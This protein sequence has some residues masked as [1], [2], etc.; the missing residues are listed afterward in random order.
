MNGPKTTRVRAYT[1]QLQVSNIYAHSPFKVH[2]TSTQGESLLQQS[3]IDKQIA[4]AVINPF[5]MNDPNVIGAIRRQEGITNTSNYQRSQAIGGAVGGAAGLA[6]GVYKYG[7]VVLAG[8]KAIGAVASSVAAGSATLSWTGVGA[9]VAGAAA[10]VAI[11]MNVYTGYQL[12]KSV[13]SLGSKEGQVAWGTYLKNIGTSM[14]N[15]PVTT[16]LSIGG[17]AA[18]HYGLSKIGMAAAKPTSSILTQ[19]VSKIINFG[20][21]KMISTVAM[22]KGMRYVGGQID[23]QLL[24]EMTEGNQA[25]FTTLAALGGDLRDM[26]SLNNVVKAIAATLPKGFEDFDTLIKRSYGD[27]EDGYS[28]LGFNKVREAYGL[29]IGTFGNGVIDMLGEVMIHTDGWITKISNSKPN[30]LT[31]FVTNEVT[32]RILG[33]ENSKIFNYFFEKTKD[34]LTGKT[35][36]SQRKLDGK[37]TVTLK[38]LKGHISNI[39]LN[40]NTKKSNNP[41]KQKNIDDFNE[42]LIK[43]EI[44]KISQILVAN[45]IRKTGQSKLSKAKV[46]DIIKIV[47]S[48][49][50]YIKETVENIA[51]DIDATNQMIVKSDAVLK[52]VLNT[53]NKRKSFNLDSMVLQELSER[54]VVFSGAYLNKLL[55]TNSTARM[56]VINQYK[57]NN[58]IDWITMPTRKLIGSKEVHRKLKDSLIKISSAYDP[59]KVKE[60]LDSISNRDLDSD[61]QTLTGMTKEQIKQMEKQL[62][63]KQDEINNKLNERKESFLNEKI[64]EKFGEKDTLQTKM[65]ELEQKRKEL[66]KPK[67]S[68]EELE[69][70]KIAYE[71]LNKELED[72]T[73]EWEEHLNI[74]GSYLQKVHKTANTISELRKIVREH[75]KNGIAIKEYEKGTGIYI[76]DD[77]ELKEVESIIEHYSKNTSQNLENKENILKLKNAVDRYNFFKL[78]KDFS[79]K[80]I[81]LIQNISTTILSIEEEFSKFRGTIANAY[82]LL[83]RVKIDLDT[84]IKEETDNLNKELKNSPLTQEKREQE[85]NA[86]I[87][88]R[89]KLIFQKYSEFKEDDFRKVFGETPEDS[90]IVKRLVELRSTGKIAIDMNY[91]TTI[92]TVLSE[93]KGEIV[94]FFMPNDIERFEVFSKYFNNESEE[95]KKILE[96]IKGLENASILGRPNQPKKINYSKETAAKRDALVI[97]LEKMFKAE[98]EDPN[99]PFTQEDYD[100]IMKNKKDN[101]KKIVNS[102]A[103]I[104]I[105]SKTK[106][107]PIHKPIAEIDITRSSLSKMALDRFAMK[108]FLETPLI[109]KDTNFNNMVRSLEID[110]NELNKRITTAEEEFN[111]KNEETLVRN[112]KIAFANVTNSSFLFALNSKYR[113]LGVLDDFVKDFGFDLNNTGN[114]NSLKEQTDKAFDSLS[115]QKV[116]IEQMENLVSE[117]SSKTDKDEYTKKIIQSV[118]ENYKRTKGLDEDFIKEFGKDETKVDTI[119]RLQD[120]YGGIVE[121]ISLKIAK[122]NNPNS[123]AASEEDVAKAWSIVGEIIDEHSKEEEIINL[124]EEINYKV[125]KRNQEIKEIEESIIILDKKIQENIENKNETETLTKERNKLNKQLEIKTK[126]NYTNYRDLIFKHKLLYLIPPEN[127]P[128]TVRGKTTFQNKGITE[129]SPFYKD[130]IQKV[131]NDE[132]M[133]L[134]EKIV[135][136]KTLPLGVFKN[137]GGFP[138]RLNSINQIKDIDFWSED[139]TLKAFELIPIEE[140]TGISKYSKTVIEF[141][142]GQGYDSKDAPYYIQNMYDTTHELISSSKDERLN[143]DFYKNKENSTLV[144]PNSNEE[145]NFSQLTQ[146]LL[147]VIRNATEGNRILNIKSINVLKSQEQDGS[148]TIKNYGKN[149]QELISNFEIIRIN[150]QKGEYVDLLV[151][152]VDTEK[153]L[154][155]INGST[156]LKQEVLG[157]ENKTG[158]LNNIRKLFE[159]SNNLIKLLTKKP[160]EKIDIRTQMF[161]KSIFEIFYDKTE[162]GE[163]DTKELINHFVYVP[164]DASDTQLAMLKQVTRIPPHKRTSF[165]R[166]SEENLNAYVKFLEDNGMD[167]YVTTTTGNVAFKK[168][169]LEDDNKKEIQTSFHEA[170]A[171]GYMQMTNK[172]L[173]RTGLDIVAYKNARKLGENGGEK[174]KFSTHHFKDNKNEKMDFKDGVNIKVKLQ[175]F[176]G[177]IKDIDGNDVFVSN[178]EDIVLVKKSVIERMYGSVEEY[179]LQEK[180]NYLKLTDRYSNKATIR[181]IDNETFEKNFDKNS[182]LIYSKSSNISRQ[183]QPQ[184]IEMYFNSMSDDRFYYDNDKSLNENLNKLYGRTEQNKLTK[185]ELRKI[186]EDIENIDSGEQYFFVTEDLE[187]PDKLG[188]YVEPK[189]TGDK[190]NVYSNAFSDEVMSAIAGTKYSYISSKDKDGKEVREYLD[191]DGLLLKFFGNRSKEENALHKESFLN[192]SEIMSGKRG[193]IKNEAFKFRQKNSI[194]DKLTSD[195]SLKPHQISITK[196]YAIDSGIA[197]MVKGKLEFFENSNHGLFIRYP[198]KGRISL[199]KV[200]IVIRPESDTDTSKIGIPLSYAKATNSDFDGDG[201]MLRSFKGAD[202]KTIEAAE[203][204]F[205]HDY[206]KV[207]KNKDGTY[208]LDPNVKMYSDHIINTG[209]KELDDAF[210]KDLLEK[211]NTDMAV[212]NEDGKIDMDKTNEFIKSRFVKD[213][214]EKTKITSERESISPKNL[215]Y[216]TIRNQMVKEFAAKNQDVIDYLSQS[217]TF[218]EEFNYWF[219]QEL[220]GEEKRKNNI[221]GITDPQALFS[222]GRELLAQDAFDFSKRGGTSLDLLDKAYELIN[223]YSDNNREDLKLLTINLQKVLLSMLRWKNSSKTIGEKR[224]DNNFRNALKKIENETEDLKKSFEENEEEVIFAGKESNI[225]DQTVEEVEGQQERKKQIDIN[226]IIEKKLKDNELDYTL[227]NQYSNNI[228]E[229]DAGMIVGENGFLIQ[230]YSN[231]YLDGVNQSLFKMLKNNNLLSPDVAPGIDGKVESTGAGRDTIGQYYRNIELVL[232]WSLVSSLMKNNLLGEAKNIKFIITL[233]NNETETFTLED[234]F[235]S[236]ATKRKVINITQK[237]TELNK[238]LF[239]FSEKELKTIQIV[240]ETS[241]ISRGFLNKISERMY[242]GI[243]DA[244]DSAASL[245]GIESSNMLTPRTYAHLFYRLGYFTNF[246][247]DLTSQHEGEETKTAFGRVIRAILSDTNDNTIEGNDSILIELKE[248]L[249]PYILTQQLITAIG[250]DNA[251]L[252][253]IYTG[254]IEI[255]GLFSEIEHDIKNPRSIK[256][257]KNNRD[258]NL[259]L[260]GVL[261]KINLEGSKDK[262]IIQEIRFIADKLMTLNTTYYNANKF[263]LLED[264]K[265]IDIITNIYN[266]RQSVKGEGEEF[267]VGG[268]KFLKED[269]T[270]F[271]ASLDESQTETIY[272]IYDFLRSKVLVSDLS[273]NQKG[274]ILTS[275]DNEQKSIASIENG[276]YMANKELGLTYFSK[277]TELNENGGKDILFAFSPV[278]ENIIITSR[279]KMT[280]VGLQRNAEFTDTFYDKQINLEDTE[281]TKEILKQHEGTKAL[282]LAGFSNQFYRDNIQEQINILRNVI[283]EDLG[284]PKKILEMLLNLNIMA[285]KLGVQKS[286]SIEELRILYKDIFKSSIAYQEK[287]EEEYDKVT[288]NKVYSHIASEQLF[289]KN[290][291]EDFFKL[292]DTINAPGI[293]RKNYQADFIAYSLL[294]RVLFNQNMVNWFSSTMPNLETSYNSIEEIPISERQSYMQKELHSIGRD[295]L[296]KRQQLESTYSMV[297]YHLMSQLTSEFVSNENKEK[298]I[299][300]AF[301]DKDKQ[302]ELRKRINDFENRKTLSPTQKTFDTYSWATDEHANK[303]KKILK[304]TLS[305]IFWQLTKESDLYP[306]KDLF[307]TTDGKIDEKELLKRTE[308]F[309]IEKMKKE[310]KDFNKLVGNKRLHTALIDSRLNLE[311]FKL[312]SEQYNSNKNV[313]KHLNLSKDMANAV[314]EFRKNKGKFVFFDTE[315][316]INGNKEIYDLSY[317]IYENGQ[318][319]YHQN[320]LNAFFD[321]RNE[322]FLKTKLGLTQKEFNNLVKRTS[323]AD[324]DRSKRVYEEFFNHAENSYLIGHSIEDNIFGD[325]DIKK[326]NE[327]YEKILKGK[328]TSYLRD[329][330][331]DMGKIKDS[332]EQFG[333]DGMDLSLI[334]TSQQYQMAYSLVQ[335]LNYENMKKFLNL[336]GG[337]DK[338]QYEKDFYMNKVKEIQEPFINFETYKQPKRIIKKHLMNLGLDEKVSE[339]LWNLFKDTYDK[340]VSNGFIIQKK[341]SLKWDQDKKQAFINLEE[342]PEESQNDLMRLDYEKGN[343]FAEAMFR[344]NAFNVIMPEIM[345]LAMVNGVKFKQAVQIRSY[346]S[347]FIKGFDENN[348]ILVS[349]TATFDVKTT[350]ALEEALRF[351]QELDIEQDQNK[352]ERLETSYLRALKK[353][354]SLHRKSTRPRLFENVGLG[355]DFEYEVNDKIGKEAIKLY[356][357]ERLEDIEQAAIRLSNPGKKASKQMGEAFDRASTKAVTRL[358]AYYNI[359]D[360]TLEEFK[361]ILNISADFPDLNDMLTRELLYLKTNFKELKANGLPDRFGDINGNTDNLIEDEDDLTIAYIEAAF[362]KTMFDEDN[363]S[364]LASIL[365]QEVSDFENTIKDED[366]IDADLKTF[367]DQ[368]ISKKIEQDFNK[369]IFKSTRV[370]LKNLFLNPKGNEEKIKEYFLNSPIYKNKA[371][372]LREMRKLYKA[373]EDRFEYLKANGIELRKGEINFKDNR[374]ERWSVSKDNKLIYLGTQSNKEFRK[375]AINDSWKEFNE[376][377]YVKEII[378]NSDLN[379]PIRE[380]ISYKE[381]NKNLYYYG[382]HY[383]NSLYQIE[384]EISKDVRRAYNGYYRRAN[385]AASLSKYQYN[386]FDMIESYKIKDG[387]DTKRLFHDIKNGFLGNNYY[388]TMITDLAGKEKELFLEREAEFNKKNMDFYRKK[389]KTSNQIDFE[390]FENSML[391]PEEVLKNTPVPY[392]KIIDIKNEDEL[393]RFI[394][395]AGEVEIGFTTKYDMMRVERMMNMDNRLSPVLNFINNTLVFFQKS[396]MVFNPGF[397][398]NMLTSGIKKNYDKIILDGN[399]VGGTKRFVSEGMKA[400]SLDSNYKLHSTNNLKYLSDLKS[401]SIKLEEGTLTDNDIDVFKNRLKNQTDAITIYLQEILSEEIGS[402]NYKTLSIFRSKINQLLTEMNKV[403]ED[404]TLT[405]KEKQQKVDFYLKEYINE[406]TK[407]GFITRIIINNYNNEEQLDFSTDE[408]KIET[409]EIIENMRLV[410]DIYKKRIIADPYGIYTRKEMKHIQRSL[411]D[412]LFNSFKENSI[413]NGVQLATKMVTPIR[414]LTSYINRVNQL[415]GIL[416]DIGSGK[417][418]MEA[419]NNSIKTFFNYGSRGKLENEMVLMFPFMSYAIRNIDYYLELINNP[420]YMTFIGNIAQGARTWYEDEDENDSPYDSNF[421]TRFAQERGWIPLGKNY[422]IKMNNQMYSAMNFLGDIGKGLEVRTNPLI[423]QIGNLTKGEDFSFG[424]AFGVENSMVANGFRAINKIAG[425]EVKTPADIMPSVFYADEFTKYT[426]YQYRRSKFGDYR[427]L[428]NDLFFQDGSR[429]KPSRN[430][431]TTSKNILYKAFVNR[432]LMEKYRYENR[433]R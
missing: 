238:K 85:L 81:D 44:S 305:N 169:T 86:R 204:A 128:F 222:L 3:L 271:K 225:N 32:L 150:L 201:G 26:T 282:G 113:S 10:I 327:E 217:L 381:Y 174:A 322:N 64:K 303:G 407:T 223:P 155:T 34:P 75:V 232:R 398:L 333:V 11:G 157:E 101:F 241:K 383:E 365:E 364:T 199:V 184:L 325:G 265:I 292:V 411:D 92:I 234:V 306:F 400:M 94:N 165:E 168:F 67:L 296:F 112:F 341:Y 139:F 162:I 190:T 331:I 385:K 130:D 230:N 177:S 54:N 404:T 263:G 310:Y 192:S 387:Y 409:K 276:L 53:N 74:E 178:L 248:R 105:R 363:P 396:M 123:E 392:L 61:K 233:A 237:G 338:T 429:R 9:I 125:E 251:L 317:V 206:S 80:N 72:L 349:D 164:K 6:F 375:Q 402:N 208:S 158:Y 212:K 378:T 63:I 272:K 35:K 275:L 295:I 69:K 31:S 328:I 135:Y 399:L 314:L 156:Y 183:S 293:K 138:V 285:Q 220:L 115:G 416:L 299:E 330:D 329:N 374:L 191:P 408:G 121:E 219:H 280:K 372:A 186:Y 187:N 297:P 96:L 172:N 170:Y 202:L 145:K 260:E 221:L 167:P 229:L 57:A 27:H 311:V 427:N 76:K 188:E 255:E 346:N 90:P 345:K 231:I 196:K 318:I 309:I 290:M 352:K 18:Y 257:G 300:Q 49:E 410:D 160:G 25:S 433:R 21:F 108:Y 213:P 386:F 259:I 370:E 73:K 356:D 22:N 137:S 106:D 287:R 111:G 216:A 132:H 247:K 367:N 258:G 302:T 368:I 215:G 141:F 87:E 350:A 266:I 249:T 332:F 253:N 351:K 320:F 343:I 243:K 319:S 339:E 2:V 294:G 91:E 179:N 104:A 286:I 68:K 78:F 207:I 109:K 185:A 197:R 51:N 224:A 256:M 194:Y 166:A 98:L 419:Y 264:E 277:R 84:A 214:S 326:L 134:E 93:S 315:N 88:K 283:E 7:G 210:G 423:R 23:N 250:G 252:S 58:I 384:D 56:A 354:E 100:A 389:I 143:P 144:K 37:E 77:E 146:D 50:K 117:M 193:S 308:D 422:G 254:I 268:I 131:I 122:K 151:P 335:A 371:E 261:K 102:F 171:P 244:L 126:Q 120:A 432:R 29:D 14:V 242:S 43:T 103:F 176:H 36:I 127:I 95:S 279:N 324:F 153:G 236:K 24:G 38:S 71:N 336:S 289:G 380:S 273:K 218:N 40:Y 59:I 99:S 189:V 270:D 19:N 307:N 55:N 321:K 358:R 30:T 413:I 118:I 205:K 246:Y 262:S 83:D 267:E 136:L 344:Q 420:D 152:K 148:F 417:L 301:E 46:E 393:K 298:L 70:A 359:E 424:K 334:E 41:D 1:P 147:S 5:Q 357:N 4:R 79:I 431:Y 274:E 425:N 149:N 28:P 291:D 48:T 269:L 388:I 337:Q 426:P 175:D 379:N 200:E 304:Y 20:G 82:I 405:V 17:M 313:L 8:A 316:I 369:E 391:D 412:E 114:V 323:V 403:D 418:K 119:Q 245:N 284:Y 62:K 163:G 342:I 394:N 348:D 235:V 180:M 361:S 42:R 107:F 401:L 421:Y 142:K 195:P 362:W 45:E 355:N 382:G 124:E 377:L 89:R 240:S 430:P 395:Q 366:L 239:D 173:G 154:F 39:V 209:Y 13:G 281:G 211:Y 226:K 52:R 428:T 390:A 340:S 347:D 414:Y 278:E 33:A 360:L 182:E 15:R 376:V 47:K 140:D 397:M 227:E 16:V 110:I 228:Y 65:Q 198:S 161:Q 288:N 66:K 406:Y 97:E 159:D 60:K 129:V 181:V 415:H 116:F 12:G 353:A 373:I 203:K 133:S 312:I